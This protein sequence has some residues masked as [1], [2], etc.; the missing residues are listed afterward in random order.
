METLRNLNLHEILPPDGTDGKGQY[1]KQESL[2]KLTVE[3]INQGN[4][5][6]N[7]RVKNMS[8]KMTEAVEVITDVNDL[9][10][11]ATYKLTETE[12]QLSESAKR[13]SGNVRNAANDLANGLLK[14][15][16]TADFSRLER[17]VELL[18]RASVAINSLAELEKTGKLEKIATA[19]K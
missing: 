17:F 5:F 11:K 10:T 6:Q 1:W 14:L 15:E 13:A 18:E 7:T 2:N 12:K 16:K 3:I 4:K 9:L 19:I 8:E